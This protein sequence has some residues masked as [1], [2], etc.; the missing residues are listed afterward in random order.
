MK[1]LFHD[2]FKKQYKKLH[3]SEKKKW[4]ER[5]DLFMKDPYDPIL[6][7]HALHGQYRDYR[8]I[9]ITGDL[10]ALYRP[11]KNEAAFFILID[12]HSN[13]YK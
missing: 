9:D 10:R 3:A 7:N 4:K 2:A 1:V 5:R 11:I 12:T 8:S 6:R 13:L